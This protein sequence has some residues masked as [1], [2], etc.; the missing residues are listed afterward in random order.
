MYWILQE[1]LH[2]E[3]AFKELISQLERQETQ[4]QLVKVI[5]FVGEIVPDVEVEGPVFVI[6]ATSMS[7]VAK[8][9]GWL[10][11]YIDENLDYRKLMYNYGDHM[12]NAKGLI[13]PFGDIVPGNIGMDRFHLRPIV[14]SKSFTGTVFDIDEFIEWQAKVKAINE[15][16]NSMTSLKYNDL[17]VASPLATIHA[18]YRFYVVDGKVIT[19]SLYKQGNTVYYASDIDDSVYDFAQRIVNTWAP[20]RAFALDIADTP[21]GYKVIE[22]NSINSAGFYACDMG[23]FVNAVNS[24]EN[25]NG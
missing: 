1:N 20:N 17:V 19:G 5:P 16:E 21:D 13:L 18:E 12:L 10:P 3:R 6:G 23:K 2:N 24:M 22:I 9:K 8:R 14:D 7:R 4:Y 25:K 11:G 15:D